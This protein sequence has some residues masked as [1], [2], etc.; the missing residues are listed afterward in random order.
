MSFL[1]KGASPKILVKNNEIHIKF[2]GTSSEN[3]VNLLIVFD[4]FNVINEFGFYGYVRVYN[5][6]Y[7]DCNTVLK[8][9]W[10]FSENKLEN[11]VRVHNVSNGQ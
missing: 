2:K 8:V 9:S 10:L 5:S 4:Q 3:K 6:L 7:N 1:L 11:A